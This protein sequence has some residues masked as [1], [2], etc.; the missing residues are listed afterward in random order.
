MSIMNIKHTIATAALAGALVVGG[1][2]AAFAAGSGDGG[3]GSG[4]G[5]GDRI[6]ALCEHQDEIVPRLTERQTSISERIATLQ[7]VSAKASAE[8]HSKFAA[9]V[10]KRIAK[11]NERLAKVTDRI[12]KAPAWIAAHC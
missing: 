3:S 6:A 10:D 2:T 11:L 8:G 4:T 5:Q 1:T 9:R 12:A 7:D